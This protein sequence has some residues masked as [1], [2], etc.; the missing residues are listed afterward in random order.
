MHDRRNTLNGRVGF[1]AVTEDGR[2]F[3]EF[4]R[5]WDE[6]P[7]DEQ[8]KI[9]EIVDSTSK[10]SIVGGAF[11]TEF[12]FSNEMVNCAPMNFGNQIE[13]GFAGNQG[14]Y[15]LTAK[16]LGMVRGDKVTELRVEMFGKMNVT[17]REFPK[18][19]VRFNAPSL[20]KGLN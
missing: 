15:T 20:R 3:T 14:G 6:V 7:D 5:L 18:S 9:V 16:I 19:S 10:A 8:Y 13:D 2:E 11:C 12:Y 17:M 4:E 1:R